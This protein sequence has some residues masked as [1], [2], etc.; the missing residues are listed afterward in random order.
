MACGHGSALGSCRAAII[1]FASDL[2]R[3]AASHEPAA[4]TGQNLELTALARGEGKEPQLAPVASLNVHINF[5][6]A[7]L[8]LL[9]MHM[10][11]LE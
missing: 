9:F 8:K 2:L 7:F 3:D 4:W 6:V 10:S 11:L 1:M 5:T